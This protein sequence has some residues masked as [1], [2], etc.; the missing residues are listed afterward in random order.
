MRVG[1]VALVLIVVAASVDFEDL[2]AFDAEIFSL[3]AGDGTDP[4]LG[5]SSQYP[6]C[7]HRRSTRMTFYET[8]K[9]PPPAGHSRQ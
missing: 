8:L 4:K 6:G 7:A 1:L 5:E 3:T 9:S 2:S